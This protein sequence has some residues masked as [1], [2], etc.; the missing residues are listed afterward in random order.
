MCIKGINVGGSSPLAFV[1][2][3][4]PLTNGPYRFHSRSLSLG[5]SGSL[6]AYNTRVFKTLLYCSRGTFKQ[7]TII[8]PI[9]QPTQ[10]TLPTTN[11]SKTAF[12]K[13]PCSITPPNL[14]S[15]VSLALTQIRAPFPL[16][17]NNGL[18][19]NTLYAPTVPASSL[20]AAQ[21]P[22]HRNADACVYDSRLAQV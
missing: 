6:S 14:R 19:H 16:A 2:F 11:A 5:L 12:S 8:R 1:S 4:R 17:N 20:P 3:L 21:F 15:K 9:H 7:L 13:A 18:T 10:N 22:A